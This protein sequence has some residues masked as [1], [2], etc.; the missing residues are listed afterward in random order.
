MWGPARAPGS[1]GACEDP[2]FI[3]ASVQVPEQLPG[4]AIA[5]LHGFV[6]GEVRT[7]KNPFYEYV[8]LIFKSI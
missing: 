1:R 3:P 8:Y 4:G 7:I 6:L 2:G 5:T